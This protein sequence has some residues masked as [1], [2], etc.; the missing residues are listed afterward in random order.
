M[1]QGLVVGRARQLGIVLGEGGFERSPSAGV[2]EVCLRICQRHQPR[3]HDG[4][5][6]GLAYRELI[7]QV[8]RLGRDQGR[9]LGSREQPPS[10]PVSSYVTALRL[11][12]KGH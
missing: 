5:R 4:R 2:R 1:C 9:H 12:R 7:G 10:R 3:E 6:R 11:S 8:H